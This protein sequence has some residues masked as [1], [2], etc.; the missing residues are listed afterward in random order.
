MVIF[1]H[2]NDFYLITI[3]VRRANCLTVFIRTETSEDHHLVNFS[4][5]YWQES[6]ETASH[7]TR[8]GHCPNIMTLMRN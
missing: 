2:V 4:Y 5:F 1:M 6:S 7:N 8:S 3:S